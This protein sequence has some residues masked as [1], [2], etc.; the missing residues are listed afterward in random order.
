M[1]LLR[2]VGPRATFSPE[3]GVTNWSMTPIRVALTYLFFTL[4]LFLF[5]PIDWPLSAWK[6]IIIVIY[7]IGCYGLFAAGY[8]VATYST[9]VLSNG[10]VSQRFIMWG[11]VSAVILLFPSAYFYAGRWPWQILD[12]IGDQREAYRGLQDTLAETAGQRTPIALL[13][14]IFAPI[15]FCVLPLG[16]IRW[17]RL[18]WWLRAGVLATVACSI[19]FSVLRGTDREFADI[20][21]VGVSAYL[22][23]IARGDSSGIAL[24]KRN[25]KAAVALVLFVYVAGN[26]FTER[27]SARLGQTTS[28]CAIGSGVC[29]DLGNPAIA[30]MDERTL[31]GSS[32]FAVSVAQGYYGLALGMDQ[33]F[34]STFG[35]GHSPALTGIYVRATGD[36]KFET[37]SFTYRNAFEAWPPESFW[38]SMMIWFA[39]DI[40][41]LGV[42][43]LMYFIGAYWAR[44]WKNATLGESDAAAVLFSLLC[45]MIAYMPANNQIFAT[46][47]GYF[48]IAFWFI[49]EVRARLRPVHV[50]RA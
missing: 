26:L 8:V 10:P 17:E 41:Y 3:K 22:V 32:I 34:K 18:S 29:A 4:A 7:T 38:S 14:G 48:I 50:I 39:N 19:I 6:R 28:V 20:L 25:W 45:V 24:I 1:A 35:L 47:D 46:F 33:P 43:P 2:P 23:R 12:V 16:I 15:T 5:W 13:R 49:M 27:K 37:R 42:L 40:S 9:P 11:A 21:I 31:F 36:K 30:W 44:R